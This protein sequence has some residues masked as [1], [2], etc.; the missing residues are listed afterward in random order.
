MTWFVR[1]DLFPGWRWPVSS[2]KASAMDTSGV[3]FMAFM[4][5]LYAFLMLVVL[6]CKTM[7]HILT[8]GRRL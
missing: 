6:P 3:D 4:V 8:A 1:R 7:F 2:L 5:K